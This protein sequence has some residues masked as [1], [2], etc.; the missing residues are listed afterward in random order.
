[1]IC[2]EFN[3]IK[4]MATNITCETDDDAPYKCQQYTIVRYYT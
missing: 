1:M 3:R 2:T 4:I